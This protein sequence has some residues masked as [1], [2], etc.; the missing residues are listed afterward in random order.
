MPPKMPSYRLAAIEALKSKLSIKTATNYEK[1]IWRMCQRIAKEKECCTQDIYADI[2]LEKVSQLLSAPNKEKRGEIFE[3]IKK[4]TTG[5]D[6]IVYNDFREK[7][8]MSI[9][10]IINGVELEPSELPCKN[11]NCKSDRTYY[12]QRQTRSADEGSTNY[13]VCSKCGSR[14]RFG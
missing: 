3:N 14:Y 10:E 2:A 13:V 7:Q 4:N 11:K 9:A 1:Q 6:S 5:W 8:A 12:Y